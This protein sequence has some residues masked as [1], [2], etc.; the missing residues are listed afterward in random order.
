MLVKENAVEF[1]GYDMHFVQKFG[2]LEATDMVLDFCAINRHPFIY[3]TYQLAGFFG[4]NRKKLFER[5]KKCDAM[6]TVHHLPKK[7]GGMRKITVPA[8]PIKAMQRLILKRI[9]PAFPVSKYAMAYRRGGKLYDN[10]APHIGKKYLLKMDLENFFGS[11]RFDMVYSAVFH[12]RHFP[13]RIGAMLTKLCCKEDVL[14]QGAPTSPAL[15]NLVMR[16]FDD[17]IGRWCEKRGIAYTRY[18]DDLAFS[19]DVPLYCVYVK[20]KTMLEEMGFTVN[21]YKT[22]FITNA[23]R[24]S[25]TGLTVNEKVAVSSAYKRTLRQACYYALRFGLDN[26]ILN[27]NKTAYIKDGKSMT[28]DYLNHLLGAVHYVLQIEPDNAWFKETRDKLCALN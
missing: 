4:I 10:A 6:Y 26:A 7:N 18:C 17:A 1:N 20:V 12:T 13:R 16:R 14:P 25:V 21:E 27:G 28:A 5:V 8:P 9:L 23:S 19:A 24:Q 3:D 22:H 11:I 2:L 15:S